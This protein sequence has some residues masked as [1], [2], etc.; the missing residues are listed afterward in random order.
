MTP[1]MVGPPTLDPT[2]AVGAALVVGPVALPSAG[3]RL[4]C[5]D[6]QRCQLLWAVM[7]VMLHLRM[8]HLL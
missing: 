6:C 3:F 5:L 4:V 1:P 8:G 7:A 2:W